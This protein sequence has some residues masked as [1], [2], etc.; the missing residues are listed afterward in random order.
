MQLSPS[1]DGL[2]ALMDEPAAR[3]RWDDRYK[4]GQYKETWGSEEPSGELVGFAAG[5]TLGGCCFSPRGG[6]SSQPGR[7]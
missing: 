4:F 2:E 3:Q 6:P 7:A 5:R 1:T